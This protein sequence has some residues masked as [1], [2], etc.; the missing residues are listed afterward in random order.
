VRKKSMKNKMN[1]VW[2]V[3]IALIFVISMGLVAAVPTGAATVYP[4]TGITMGSVTGGTAVWDAT[5][6][7]GLTGTASAK[8]AKTGGSDGSTY[9]QFVP[10]TGTTLADLATITGSFKYAF[11]ATTANQMG[12]QLELRFTAPTNTNPEGAGHVDVTLMP[13]QNYTPGD[14]NFHTYTVASTST[15]AVYYGSSLANAT[16]SA[17]AGGQTLASTVAAIAA[18]DTTD[19]TATAAW[20][21]TRV[22][23]ELWEAS[24]ART[25]YI[26]DVTLAGTTYTMEPVA[27]NHAYYSTSGTATITVSDSA[28]NLNPVQFDTIKAQVV[29]TSDPIGQ[30]YTLTETGVNTGIFTGTVTLIPAA[31]PATGQ[32]V[33]AS[34][35]TIT[36]YYGAYTSSTALTLTTSPVA[37]TYTTTATVDVTAPVFGVVAPLN[38]AT[39]TSTTPTIT[40]NY[41]DGGSGINTSTVVMKVNG[42]TVTTAGPSTTAVSYTPGTAFTAGSTVSVTVD[43]SDNAGNAAIQKAWSFTIPSAFNATSDHTTVAA[44]ATP[45]IIIG[46]TDANGA[47]YDSSSPATGALIN[48]VATLSGPGV[49]STFT[50]TVDTTASH[51]FSVTPTQA[52]TITATVVGTIKGASTDTTYTRTL[53]IAVTG[54]NVTYSP[55]ADVLLNTTGN[56]SATVTTSSGAPVNTGIVVIT[57]A[58]ATGFQKDINADGTLESF[59]TITIDGTLG[60]ITYGALSPTEAY[61]V[62]NG[63]YAVT[64][65]KY[66]GLGAVEIQAKSGS[67]V[68]AQFT[69]AYTVQPA[70]NITLT[71]APAKLTAGVDG[72]SAITVTVTN[73]ATGAAVTDIS[74][75][76]VGG[77][78]K[79]FTAASNVYT[80]TGTLLYTT[81]QTLTV[82]AQNAG[83]TNYGSASLTVGLPTV[84]YVITDSTPTVRT[85]MLTST[86]YSIAVTAVDANGTAMVSPYIWL[87]TYVGTTPT[88]AAQA[89]ATAVHLSATGT[90]TITV[91]N[92]DITTAKTLVAKVSGDST[93]GNG[94]LL[95]TPAISVQ[96]LLY[97]IS[98]VT[99]TTG[100]D[101]TYTVTNNYGDAVAAL[102]VTIVTPSGD[103]VN[104]TTNSSGQFVYNAP[105]AGT[106]SFSMGS[107]T[108]VAVTVTGTGTGV[109]TLD[110]L[111][112]KIDAIEAKL[113]ACGTFYSFVDTW[114]TTLQTK[115]D[116]MQ[117][118]VTA[119]KAVTDT[120][121][122]ANIAA[123]GTNITAIKAK[124]DLITA[125]STGG[126][127]QTSV[128][129][130][131][132]PL[133]ASTG[134]ITVVAQG[135]TAIQGT[136]S[137]QSS[138]V[139][140]KVQ[141]YT[142]SAW[143][144]VVASGALNGSY[145]ISGFGVK[146]TNATTTAMTVDY[147]IVYQ[148]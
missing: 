90:G 148:K 111:G 9:V 71:F 105:A 52:G 137:V 146:I 113:D 12:P 131:A 7:T 119:I 130:S 77:V 54:F 115:I 125:G 47:G 14:T 94:A 128:A 144:P 50:E 117:T 15:S 108:A 147:V 85:L 86:A 136:I 42:V 102:S 87:G 30:I 142:G 126:V 110:S 91:L 16:F 121:S 116:A 104:K 93:V 66:A 39:A 31:P 72:A 1:L 88:F 83:S 64:G 46:Y 141:V 18:A 32:L 129:G 13:L 61:A 100:V 26:D 6:I 124:T 123:M 27:L 10:N 99:A 96:A 24:I 56:I 17:S 112:L 43:V 11:A 76:T 133:A 95:L 132:L 5:A 48:V 138:K 140:Y 106:Y 73:T 127:T 68:E 38:G 35:D 101:K 60:T 75:I 67:T 25:V 3:A 4:A 28:A 29:S 89:F 58:T 49:S 21:L 22:R 37:H 143:I 92:T 107:Q 118:D 139:G 23:V 2:R 40:A 78:S 65:I 41:S 80:I 57:A 122:T 55:T 8:L 19:T 135:T 109:N 145:P 79:T 59:Q 36:V 98:A 82:S 97:S 81:A 34:T 70:A 63:L 53:T 134:S 51:S 69:T 103:V 120:L 33:V 74:T 114:F 20:T 84:S 45:S 44:A 62:A